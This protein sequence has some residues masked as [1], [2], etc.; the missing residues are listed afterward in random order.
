M[1]NQLE[2]QCNAI[3]LRE[4]GVPVLESLN[5]QVVPQ[6]KEWIASDRVVEVDYGDI[7]GEVIRRVLEVH[8]PAL[9]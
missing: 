8:A 1:K 6:L 2:Q 3:A 7:A 9:V 5:E 4:M